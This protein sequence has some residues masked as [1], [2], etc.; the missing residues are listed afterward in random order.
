VFFH[1]LRR[2]SSSQTVVT[3]PSERE[4]RFQFAALAV[5]TEAQA[6]Q[7]SATRFEAA[8][9]AGLDATG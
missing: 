4:I 2:M 6:A 3:V 7:P 5:A 9:A 8:Y 1:L